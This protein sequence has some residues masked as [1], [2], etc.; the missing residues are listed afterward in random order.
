MRASQT[1]K[2]WATCAASLSALVLAGC[3]GLNSAAPA[4]PVPEHLFHDAWFQPPA[5][6]VRADAVLALSPAMRAFM[7][8]DI[9]HLARRENSPQRALIQALYTPNLLRLE[10]DASMTRDAAQAFD[11]RSGNCLSLVL[12]TAAF[13]H[14]LDLEVNFH[15]AD[16]E[17]TWSRRGNLLV[18]SSHVNVSL[19]PRLMSQ[20]TRRD[21]ALLTVD[22]L[23]AQD[24]QGLRTRDIGQA[25]VLAMYFNNRAAESLVQGQFDQSYAF[26]REA[27]RQDPAFL[28]AY[29]TLGLVYR[30]HGQ[31]AQAAATFEHVLALDPTQR[32]A[33]ANLIDTADELGRTAQAR[34]WRA[35]LARLEP[36]PPFYFLQLGQAAARR[37]DW[38][39]ALVLF[40]RELARA[41]YSAEV[42][43]WVAQATLQLG[44][45]V[46]ARRHLA[47]AAENSL[48]GGERAL[49]S[50]KLDRLNAA[51]HP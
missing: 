1:L 50:A 33:M 14:A 6:P 31:P 30:R 27:L 25:T 44:D 18:R 38:P 48:S 5:E 11:A 4:A 39:A 35:A 28:P 42:H 46:S 19:G 22:F 2:R 17:E 15:S 8:S 34:Q 29:N 7:V 49:Y 47:L 51:R 36:Y 12:M 45:P 10:Y 41:D 40:K 3:A 43:F 9:A 16:S 24:L 23:P 26:A 37:G 21:P 13:A 32:Q 20:G